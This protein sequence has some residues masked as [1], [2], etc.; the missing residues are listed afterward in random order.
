M[1]TLT[2]K[3]IAD[4][5]LSRLN[6]EAGDTMSPLKLQKLL[7][8]AQA[9]H[10][11]FFN[12]KPLFNEPIQAWR[13][14]PVVPSQY[15]RF[16]GLTKYVPIPVDEYGVEIMEVTPAVENLLL[17]ICDIYGEHQASYLEELTHSET[18]WIDARGDL[19]LYASCTR[20]I[21]HESMLSFYGQKIVNE[22][23]SSAA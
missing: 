23:Q 8:Y 20:E 21:S 4:W 17:D 13:H 15:E 11:V 7:Y 10:L 18:P 5:F 14:G 22:Q 2:A 19:P 1:M 6:T 12:S 9:W 16:A 3:N